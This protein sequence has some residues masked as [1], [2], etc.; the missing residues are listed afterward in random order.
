M[1]NFRITIVCAAILGSTLT[2]AQ[3]YP[4]KEINMEVL[5][6]E[7]FGFQDGDLNY[8]ELYENMAQLLAHKINLNT[9]G[10]E[11]LRFLNLLTEQQI[12]SLLSYRTENGPLLSVYELQAVPG[13]DMATIYKIVA[14]VRVDNSSTIPLIKRILAEENNYLILRYDQSLE[15]KR[16][17]EANTDPNNR[18]KGN[19]GDLYLR[20]RISK[21]GDFSIG[22]TLDKDAGEEIKWNATTKQYGFDFMS[23]HAQ[24]MNKRKLKNLIVGDYQTQFG[25]GLLLGGSFGYGKGSE[26][27]MTV[28]RSNLGFLPYTSAN[29]VGYKRGAAFT[30]ELI[31]HF[32]ISA[33][34]SSAWRD[35]TV[36]YDTL[37]NSAA[38][39]FQTTG[40]HRN[41]AE[42]ATRNSNREQH[43]GTIVNFQKGAWDAGMIFTALQYSIPVQREV[44][45]YNQFSFSGSLLQQASAFVNYTFHNVTFFSEFAKT[46]TAG[47]G[48]TAGLLGSL[49]PKLDIALHY[50][51]YQRDFYSPYSN[52]FSENSSP[53]N[54]S[55]IYWGWK[56]R[57][58][59]KFFAS[60]YV[61]FFQFPWLRFRSYMP[62]DGHEWLIRLNYQPAR[63]TIL[64]IQ[65]REESK[66]RN[67]STESNLYLTD[68]GV[69]RNY[70]LNC[71][72]PLTDK[73]KMKTR[74]QFSTYDFN[75]LQTAGM[76]ILQDI[77]VD[78]GKLN[79][80]ARYA[81]FDTDD[82]DN[83]QYVFERDVWLA[84]SLPAYSG[85]GVRNYLLAEYSVNKKLSLWFRY[86]HTRY[87][88]RDEIGS[89]MDR[90]TGNSKNDF[91]V[92]ARIK[93]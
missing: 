64:F 16:G 52:A 9:A 23:F 46:F 61:D 73:I 71:D 83:R 13:F 45:R 36:N 18:F 92:Q 28:R 81:L 40:F 74:A 54:E 15:T 33:F 39:S 67:T 8:Q 78:L 76:V 58:N 90:I 44:N 48:L 75:N 55:G 60:G 12:Q 26:A 85:Q 62:S 6:D 4:H 80:T 47:Y 17:F 82:Y 10:A 51:N 57:W 11:A 31:K 41:N 2:S 19:D 87:T 20:F 69:K 88:D 14:F 37:E 86:A 77:S 25:Q 29:E 65:L 27:V 68:T 22:F 34:Y 42:L 30:L 53:Q 59:R 43:T 70:W 24:V 1:M 35:A 3:E 84:Y 5:A 63:N 91:R 66:V 72:Y 32:N 89:G 93:L 49:T 21:P 56:Y 79:L 38:S 50:R 7:L